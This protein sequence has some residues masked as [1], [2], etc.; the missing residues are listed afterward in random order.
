MVRLDRRALCSRGLALL[1][2]VG[3]RIYSLSGRLLVIPASRTVT[4]GAADFSYF[5]APTYKLTFTAAPSAGGASATLAGSFSGPTGSSYALTFPDGETRTGTLTN[6]S[7]RVTWTPALEANQSSANITVGGVDTN[8]GTLSRPWSIASLA[9]PLWPTTLAPWKA[10]NA[11]MAG[12]RI[13]VIGDQG[14]YADVFTSIG[15]PR[16]VG[17]YYQPLLTAPFGTSANPTIIASCSSSGS[18]SG[19]HLPGTVAANFSSGCNDSN[20][21]GA[22]NTGSALFGVSGTKGGQGFVQISGFEYSGGNNAFFHAHYPAPGRWAGIQV[23]NCYFH[24]LAHNNSAGGNPAIISYRGVS[25]DYSNTNT[26]S[27]VSNCYAT[28]CIN[29]ASDTQHA[30]LLYQSWGSDHTSCKYSA[31]VCTTT[32]NDLMGLCSNKNTGQY[33]N[34]CY[35][36]YIDLR[37]RQFPSG[38]PVMTFNHTSDDDNNNYGE[39]PIYDYT[40]QNCIFLLNSAGQSGWFSGDG[41]VNQPYNVRERKHFRFNTCVYPS[42]QADGIRTFGTANTLEAVGNIF[43]ANCS[44]IYVASIG[45]TVNSPALIDQNYYS[46]HFAN[47]TTPAGATGPDTKYA[48]LAA[49][50]AF[51]ATVPGITGGND[52]ASIQGNPTFAGGFKYAKAWALSAKDPGHNAATTNGLA[53]GTRCDMGAYGGTDIDSGGPVTQIGPSWLQS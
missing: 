29:M 25:G 20:N 4:G 9:N 21:G 7:N 14:P 1:A 3:G 26:D 24:G 18:A 48:T 50:R 41:G 27:F 28:N 2:T 40:V 8:P 10:N 5:I 53:G 38:T 52:G 51:L 12:Q 49:W 39:G 47:S 31:I 19:P 45:C 15:S 16:L 22:P 23:S 36:C 13:G 30:W 46:T 34:R 35:N 32:P 6:G 44:G 43:N 11:R 17:F 37:N 42:S 33:G